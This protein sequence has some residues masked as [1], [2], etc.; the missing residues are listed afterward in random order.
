MQKPLLQI[1]DP[2]LMRVIRRLHETA[3]PKGQVEAIARAAAAA[4]V[5]TPPPGLLKQMEQYGKIASI[6]RNIP[7]APT[8]EE[9]Q[10]IGERQRK[11]AIRLAQRGWFIPLGMT[12]GETR[13]I[14]QAVELDDLGK[15]QFTIE[16]HLEDNLA[17]TR[18]NLVSSFPD[19]TPVL[20]QA[21]ELHNK[22]YY[23]GS[24]ALFIAIAGPDFAE[25]LNVAADFGLINS[26]D[27]ANNPFRDSP[28]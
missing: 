7:K 17:S 10:A 4:K 23:F 19:I 18:A 8:P 21:F 24:V 25:R 20:N 13:E 22:K 2:A 28:V 3:I 1:F 11:A 9:I 16:K 27:A 5:F 26:S 15:C 12:L 6:L 14:L